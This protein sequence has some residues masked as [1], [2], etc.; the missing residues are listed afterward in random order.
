MVGVGECADDL[1]SG[2]DY[3]QDAAIRIDLW[4]IFLLNATQSL[5]RGCVAG[6]DNQR[7]A[8]RKEFLNGLQSKLIDYIERTCSIGSTCI[9]T[10]VDVVVLRH[11]LTNTIQDGE[12]AQSGVEHT[13]RS[14]LPRFQV[15]CHEV[16]FV[17]FSVLP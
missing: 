2:A 7:T 17:T 8:H 14:T 6:K 12:S 1:C 13:D 10:Q 3:T 16:V 9:I 11:S 4:Q 15:V 5:G